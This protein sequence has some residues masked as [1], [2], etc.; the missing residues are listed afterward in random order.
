MDCIAKNS[1]LFLLAKMET[2]SR[3]ETIKPGN[4]EQFTFAFAFRYALP[5]LGLDEGEK[6]LHILM[7]DV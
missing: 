1:E 2:Y 3:C 5:P 4:K 6:L 7:L